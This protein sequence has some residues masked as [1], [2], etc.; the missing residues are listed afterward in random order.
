MVTYV[1][2]PYLNDVR[3]EGEGG[4]LKNCQ[5]LRTNSTDRLREMRMKGGGRRGVKK[6]PKICGRHVSMAP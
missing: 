6:N 5:L 1:K 3:T 4:G 2:G